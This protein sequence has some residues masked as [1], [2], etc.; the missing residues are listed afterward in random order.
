[1]RAPVSW[2]AP[3]RD[4][5]LPPP[6]VRFETPDRSGGKSGKRQVRHLPRPPAPLGQ[7]RGNCFRS[8]LRTGDRISPV[9]NVRRNRSACCGGSFGRLVEGR[10]GGCCER[11]G[12]CE[13]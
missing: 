13:S 8:R 1:M 7:N 12:V 10:E 9:Q 11:G 3:C 2:P 4:G 6:P 5:P